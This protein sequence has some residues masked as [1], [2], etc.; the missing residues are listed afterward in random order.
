MDIEAR[1]LRFAYGD[2][3]VLR[4]FSLTLRGG[5]VYLLT[6]ASGCGKTTLLRLLLGLLR[7]Q[8]GSVTPGVR[9][10]AVFQE[11]RLLPGRSAVENLRFVLRGQTETAALEALLAELLPP[12]CLHEPVE[13]LSGGM[14]RRVAVA[15]ALFAPS[16]CLLMDE[17]L[18]GLDAETRRRVVACIFRHRNGRTLLVATHHPEEFAGHGA[19]QI[20]L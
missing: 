11:D 3:T 8:R 2:K 9:Y 1:A 7:P 20:A 13:A 12:A 16:D 15:R 19:T 5:G 10:G 4:D 17:P 18:A 6:G 14:R